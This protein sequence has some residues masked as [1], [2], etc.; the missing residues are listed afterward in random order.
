MTDMTN[1]PVRVVARAGELPRDQCAALARVSVQ[2]PDLA[3]LE[4]IAAHASARH[5]KAAA[6][7]AQMQAQ[8]RRLH[9]EALFAADA[10]AIAQRMAT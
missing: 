9:A 1:S 8:E 7:L 4:T 6:R 3:A 10:L 5:A 2:L